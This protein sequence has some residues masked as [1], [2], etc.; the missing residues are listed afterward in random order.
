MR[1]VMLGHSGVGKTSYIASMYAAF[2]LQNSIGGFG[3]ST[4]NGDDREHL[5][6]LYRSVCDGTYP[7]PTAAR[8]EYDFRLTYEDTEILDFTWADYRG[9]DLL[10]SSDA[11]AGT[12]Q[13]DLRDCDGVLVFVDGTADSDWKQRSRVGRMINLVSSALES[14]T[15]GLP[16]GVVF[17]KTDLVDGQIT[18][19]CVELVAGLVNSIERSDH[20]VGSLIP[21][22][23]GA[24]RMHVECPL[25]FILHHGIAA[26]V[27]SLP[28]RIRELRETSIV[29][30]SRSSEC[31]MRA[32]NLRN[33]AEGLRQSHRQQPGLIKW[34][35]K[36]FTGEDDYDR[37]QKELRKAARQKE[38]AERLATDAK[39]ALKQS[40]QQYSELK[41]LEGPAKSL[42]GQLAWLEIIGQTEKG[43]AL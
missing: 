12:L 42:D 36:F 16:L 34:L 9:G 5:L 6:E 29:Q 11:G 40:D 15:Q 39:I 4:V 41:K 18:D 20:V 22:A 14:V 27:R 32:R 25:L 28:P 26:Q 43:Y 23:C 37:C 13:E 35:D 38:E 24:E 8:S 19:A 21:I 1:I 3:L 33:K 2:H 17:T 10:E 7:P 30:S 31:E